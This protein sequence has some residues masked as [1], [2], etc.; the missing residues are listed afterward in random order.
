MSRT[1]V[2]AFGG[3][4][5]VSDAA[6]DSIPEQYETVR[7]T[8][9]PLI[10]MIEQDWRLVVSHGNG[11]Q[12]GFITR[13]SELAS[14]EVD[15]VP[16]DYAVAD[17]Q[18]AIG[19]MFVKAL[20]NELRRRGLD[21]PVVAV[22]TQSVV[23]RD[24]PAFQHPTKPV[25]SFLDEAS[26]RERAAALGWTIRGFCGSKSRFFGLDLRFFFSYTR[27]L[28]SRLGR[29]ASA[30]AWEGRGARRHMVCACAINFLFRVSF[31]EDALRF[32]KLNQG[33]VRVA[34]QSS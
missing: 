33:R 11:P 16:V 20:G 21:H 14:N 32:H 24:D 29:S 34:G 19:Y 8:V 22:V 18:G 31:P 25:G 5:L 4:A 23:D 13:R 10:D 28:W 1:A 12:V 2:V 9:P 15:P 6:H 3:N 30:F 26:A 17:T 27:T 7:R